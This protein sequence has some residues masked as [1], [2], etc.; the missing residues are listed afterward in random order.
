MVHLLRD[1]DHR[2]K[3]WPNLPKGHPSAARPSR[4]FKTR[5]FP[6]PSYEG[7]GFIAESFIVQVEVNE[8]YIF[9]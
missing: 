8:T 4:S 7:F 2:A 3:K 1:L 6:P 5:R 9:F